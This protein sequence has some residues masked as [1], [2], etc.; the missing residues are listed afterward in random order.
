MAL[1]RLTDLLFGRT[2]RALKRL[3][4]NA[5]AKYTVSPGDK[6]GYTKTIS[7]QV[8]PQKGFEIGIRVPSDE[9]WIITDLYVTGSPAVDAIITMVK[10]DK[11]KIFQSAPL[12]TYNYANPSRSRI[13]PIMLK[14]NETL[15]L[16]AQLLADYTGSTSTD[17]VFYMT[18]ERYYP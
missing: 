1:D 8:D 14:S 6:S 18:I 7:I 13:S 10:N 17:I 9:T 2:T 5:I 4:I 15:T 3:T 11:E 12:S 16:I